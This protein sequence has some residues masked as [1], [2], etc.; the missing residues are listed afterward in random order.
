MGVLMTQ[1]S[2]LPLA[3]SNAEQWEQWHKNL[4][5]CVGRGKA[6]DLFLRLW[7]K[8]GE[9]GTDA[10][11]IQLR[12][13]LGT[14]GLVLT[15]GGL[16]KTQDF[17]AGVG[18]FLGGGLSAFG[19]GMKILWYGLIGAIFVGTLGM[20]YLIIAKP[21]TAGRIAGAVATKGKSEAV[22]GSVGSMGGK[23]SLPSSSAK[24]KMISVKAK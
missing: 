6:N 21:E 3:S 22:M 12:E 16:K 2:N 19:T 18:D 10:S 20:I 7:Q 23:K 4:I 11:T 5:K 24:P 9:L 15:T 14:Q 13:Y 8:R 17:L 1:C